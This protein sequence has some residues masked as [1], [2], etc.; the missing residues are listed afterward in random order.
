[1]VEHGFVEHDQ[2]IAAGK[3]AIGLIPLISEWEDRK[4]PLLIAAEQPKSPP[5]EAFRALR[6]SLQRGFCFSSTPRLH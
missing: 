3:P 5:S 1:M 4:T 2:E 6:T